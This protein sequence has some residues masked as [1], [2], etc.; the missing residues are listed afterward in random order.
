LD[1][2]AYWVCALI[3]IFDCSQV[4]L[5]VR[6]DFWKETGKEEEKLESF[7]RK[8]DD[9]EWQPF[10]QFLQ[11]SWTQSFLLIIFFSE[12]T[13]RL[14]SFQAH[15]CIILTLQSCHWMYWMSLHNLLSFKTVKCKGKNDS[16][17]LHF[18]STHKQTKQFINFSSKRM[19]SLTFLEK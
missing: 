6:F 12:E 7:Q 15:K 19:I 8:I 11:H 10:L 17:F 18:Y 14:F 5:K 9:D 2:L 16:W 13:M 3:A 4:K 1:G